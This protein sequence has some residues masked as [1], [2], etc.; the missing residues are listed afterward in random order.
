MVHRRA[1]NTDNLLPCISKVSP[2]GSKTDRFTGAA[3]SR[4]QYAFFS[5]PCEPAIWRGR[6]CALISPIGSV[7]ECFGFS[8]WGDV[9]AC[10]LRVTTSIGGKRF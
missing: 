2:D 9:V 8:I 1:G 7:Q 6:K 4:L 5:A 10:L 3:A